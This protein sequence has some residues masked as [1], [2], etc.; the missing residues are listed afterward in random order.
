MT[1]LGAQQ[2]GGQGGTGSGGGDAGAGGAAGAGGNNGGGGGGQA[3]WRDSLPEDLKAHGSIQNFSDVP[4]LVRS[5]IS[6]QAA[7]SKKGIIPPGQNA[8]EQEMNAFFDQLGRPALDKYEVKAPEGRKI[9]DERLKAFKEA[10]HKSGLLP[11]QAQEVLNFYEAQE[12]AQDKARNEALSKQ[13]EENQATL[14]KE[15]GE[16]FEKN[17]KL[18]NRP[19]NELGGDEFREWVVKGGHGNDPVL[20]R[21]LLKVEGLMKEDQ[22]RGEGG[23]L[24]GAMSPQQMEHEVGKLMQEPAYWDAR[25]SGHAAA[26]ARVMDLRRRMAPQQRTG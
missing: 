5:F 10:V 25:N 14:K 18:A 17:G 13:A 1:V 20:A 6:A 3:S 7:I 2:N 26:V 15:W 4:N 19:I 12:A 11:K 16:A 9:P 21:F 8:S 22:L 23:S 24:D